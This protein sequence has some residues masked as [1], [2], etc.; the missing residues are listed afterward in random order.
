MGRLMG[1]DLALALALEGRSGAHGETAELV[2]LAE[3]LNALPE[4]EIDQ[5][6]AAALEARLLEE[7]LDAAP[8]I[9][10]PALTVVSQPADAPEAQ[11][12]RRAPVVTLPR[13]RVS[14]RRSVAAVAAAAALAAFPVA[15]AASSLPDSPFYGLK[16]LIERAEIALFGGPTQDAFAHL[17]HANVRLQ[18]ARQM[19]ALGYAD[20]QIATVLLD[21]ER[22]VAKAGALIDGTADDAVTLS[23][24]FDAARDIEDR[25]KDMENETPAGPIDLVILGS[26]Q[27]Q[28]K[29]ADRLGF[30]EPDLTIP[31]IDSTLMV[32]D[33]TGGATSLTGG[34]AGTGSSSGSGSPKSSG[35][36]S[37]KTQSRESGGS[38]GE[39]SGGGGTGKG[40]SDQEPPGCEIP[41][42]ANGF[43]DL[44]APLVKAWCP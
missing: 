9:G 40:L 28:E 17:E 42:S 27:L 37:S 11:P 22:L 32:P 2:A 14:V 38:G 35:G 13:R 3:G 44:M 41:G 26:Q 6:W 8:A 39:S 1:E 25:A 31:V 36:T 18:E 4:P 43:G 16:R 7:D 30:P 19:N 12:V 10:R 29:L 5:T 33:S 20:D 24:L 23:R 21:A 15:A 34:A